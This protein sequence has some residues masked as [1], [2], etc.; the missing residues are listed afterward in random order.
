MRTRE[1]ALWTY[2]GQ[3]RQS[4]DRAAERHN[5]V[6]GR[7]DPD[8]DLGNRTAGRA[9]AA[10]G[11]SGSREKT[12]Q[13]RLGSAFVS[14]SHAVSSAARRGDGRY[15]R[16]QGAGSFRLDQ[17]GRGKESAPSVGPA[18]AWE[19]SRSGLVDGGRHRLRN[20]AR[21]RTRRARSCLLVTIATSSTANRAEGR[22][23]KG[24][25]SGRRPSCPTCSLRKPEAAS[26]RRPSVHIP[27][28]SRRAF[29]NSRSRPRPTRRRSVAA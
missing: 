13:A 5:S 16:Q 4:S 9:H 24:S 15:G 23:P 14:L 22:Y 17:L 10:H 1:D 3:R 28:R 12:P 29:R 18:P 11:R 27:C 19:P 21:R 26:K 20:A 25:P 2:R 6:V 7:R 8:L